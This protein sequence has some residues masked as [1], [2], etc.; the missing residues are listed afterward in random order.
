MFIYMFSSVVSHLGPLRLGPNCFQ[1]LSAPRILYIGSV[2]WLAK[3]SPVHDVEG[4]DKNVSFYASAPGFHSS[5]ILKISKQ[6]YT[7][8]FL[9]CEE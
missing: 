5:K 6:M 2:S 3:V 9:E 1:K 4:T 7:L 8:F